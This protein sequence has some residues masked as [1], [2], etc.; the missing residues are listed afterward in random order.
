[1]KKTIDILKIDL[2]VYYSN[3]TDVSHSV[4]ASSLSSAISTL[5]SVYGLTVDTQRV[6]S[7]SDYKNDIDMESRLAGDMPWQILDWKS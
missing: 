1:M 3:G 2:F 4:F 7:Y 6:A 5:Q